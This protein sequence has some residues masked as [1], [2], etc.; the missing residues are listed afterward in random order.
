MSEQ[1]DLRKFMSSVSKLWNSQQFDAVLKDVEK[2]L[3]VSAIPVENW[4]NNKM[5]G[6]G[7]G[8]YCFWYE[9]EKL[10]LKDFKVKYLEGSDG[11]SVSKPTSKWYDTNKPSVGIGDSSV[12]AYSFY[13]G[14]REM[15]LNRISQHVGVIKSSKSTYGMHLKREH[16]LEGKLYV[17]YWMLPFEMLKPFDKYVTQQV[18]TFLETELRNKL[19]PWVGKQ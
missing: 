5:T 6:D 11:L 17:G 18:L 7:P 10:K 13:L 3:A 12:K 19:A 14:K 2:E 15:V 9:G 16:Q 1:E 8:I 4:A